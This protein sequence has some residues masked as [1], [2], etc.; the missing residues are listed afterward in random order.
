MMISPSQVFCGNSYCHVLAWNPN[1]PGGGEPNII[2][3]VDLDALPSAPRPMS[4]RPPLTPGMTVMVQA[5]RLAAAVNGHL[6]VVCIAEL[7]EPVDNDTW[8]VAVYAGQSDPLPQ[9]YRRE[10]ILGTP[11]PGLRYEAVITD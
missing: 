10:E 5:F 4:P 11:S 2:D 1:E 9:M 8:W 6:P 3:I 7:L